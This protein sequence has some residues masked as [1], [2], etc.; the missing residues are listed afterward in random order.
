G[1]GSASAPAPAAATREL[2]GR[3][4]TLGLVDAHVHLDKAF[5]SAR[6]P[7]VEGTLA[8]AIRVTREAKQRFT[9]QDIRAR[10]R[11]RLHLAARSGTP[12]LRGPLAAGPTAP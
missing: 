12:A 5:L 3:L 7:G 10:A 9:A 4:V 6:A 8:E 1:A 2:G 11:Q